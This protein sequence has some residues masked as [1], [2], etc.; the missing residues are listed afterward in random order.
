MVTETEMQK[1]NKQ[2]K[3]NYQSR[4]PFLKDT[5]KNKDTVEIDF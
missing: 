1:P 3:P 2:Q 5:Q 4:N